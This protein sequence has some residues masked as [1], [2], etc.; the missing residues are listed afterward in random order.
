MTR[1]PSVQ[2]PLP[3]LFLLR[4]TSCAFIGRYPEALSNNMADPELELLRI[5]PILPS[6]AIVV[7]WLER[8]GGVP[9]VVVAPVQAKKHERGDHNPRQISEVHLLRPRIGHC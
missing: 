8:Y 9:H 6:Y 7:G 2:S 3:F 5:T 4:Q 1:T